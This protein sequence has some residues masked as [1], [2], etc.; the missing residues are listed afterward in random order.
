VPDLSY[1]PT[2]VWGDEYR[3]AGGAVVPDVLQQIREQQQ[4]REEQ[5]RAAT[6]AADADAQASAQRTQQADYDQQQKNFIDW[7]TFQ[8]ITE[9]TEP[10]RQYDGYLGALEQQLQSMGYSP[11]EAQAESQQFQRMVPRPAEDHGFF[12][13]L[14][15]SAKSGFQSGTQ[16]TEAFNAGNDPETLA[17]LLV[18]Q[19]TGNNNPAPLKTTPTTGRP[20]SG[21]A[22]PRSITRKGCS[23]S[24]CSRRC[25]LIPRSSAA[26]WVA[27]WARSRALRVRLPVSARVRAQ[28]AWRS[29]WAARC[30]R[31]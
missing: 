28:A 10:G 25:S 27:R 3:D 24:S 17:R 23:T 8:K 15:E 1:V 2:G 29:T 5:Y 4:A 19:A 6:A 13:N 14:W 26:P 30:S 9:G 20:S 11:E 18:E 31:G 12:G 16:A 21:V 7:P 22:R